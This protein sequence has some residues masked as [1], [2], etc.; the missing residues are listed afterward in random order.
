VQLLRT[1]QSRLA[2]RDKVDLQTEPH[3]VQEL[4]EA[5]TP[6]LAA[7][8]SVNVQPG[9]FLSNDGIFSSLEL[10]LMCCDATGRPGLWAGCLI[11][12]DENYAELELFRLRDDL[13]G[14]GIG[15]SVIRR[16]VHV[17]RDLGLGALTLRAEEI[18][19]YA[20][21][22]MGFD[23]FDEEERLEVLDRVSDFA[24]R[25]GI[26]QVDLSKI[27]HSWDL[28]HLGD[29]RNSV[30][31]NYVTGIDGRPI[32]LGK[33]LILQSGA[34]W[35]GILTMVEENDGYVLLMN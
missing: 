19:A 33:A 35:S 32:H 25:A 6:E 3:L 14:L 17:L 34:T 26:T 28:A 11:D 12:T 1:W 9:S 10:R 13:Q 31:G 27:R 8:W 18:G 21:A 20:W 4:L 24:S 7:E 23:F 5:F 22:T 29:D 2:G 15:R 16:V 30:A